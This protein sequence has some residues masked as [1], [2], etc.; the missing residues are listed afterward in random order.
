[1]KQTGVRHA[2][3]FVAFAVMF[4][5]SC[6]AVMDCD[7]IGSEFYSSLRSGQYEKAV[8]LVDASVFKHTDKNRWIEGFKYRDRVFGHILTYK[9]IDFETVTEDCV[10]RVGIK[11]KVICTNAELFEKLEFVGYKDGYKITFYRFNTDSTL[12][13]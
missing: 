6:G 8:S 5:F 10:T 1:M 11:Y 13:D 9:R 4:L 12:V 3:F 2:F 7:S